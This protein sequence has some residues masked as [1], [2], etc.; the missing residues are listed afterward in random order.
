MLLRYRRLRRIVHFIDLYALF[1]YKTDD[2]C[3]RTK[4]SQARIRISSVFLVLNLTKLV[5][6]YR[7]MRIPGE[8]SVYGVE[9]HI[10]FG[11]VFHQ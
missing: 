7:Q 8:S 2:S 3:S 1:A 4:L 5:Y 11:E 10:E 9:D 6:R